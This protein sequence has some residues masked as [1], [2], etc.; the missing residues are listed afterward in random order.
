MLWAGL[1][2]HAFLHFAPSRLT[3]EANG[4]RAGNTAMAAA[5]EA[6]PFYPCS[7]ESEPYGGAHKRSGQFWSWFSPST[8]TDILGAELRLLGLLCLPAEPYAGPR[9]WPLW[10]KTPLVFI[11]AMAHQN[12]D[13]YK[14]PRSSRRG[15]TFGKALLRTESRC[16]KYPPHLVRNKR[17][18]GTPGP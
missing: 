6:L 7:L 15:K 17:W 9:N 2:V 10:S 14:G 4:Q 16:A 11:K 18:S 8:F 1:Y 3:Q 13:L 5:R 12:A